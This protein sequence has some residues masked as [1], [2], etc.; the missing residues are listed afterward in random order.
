MPAEASTAG[1][2]LTVV[3]CSRSRPAQLAECLERLLALPTERPVS[4]VVVDNAPIDNRAE[5]VVRAIA[6]RDGRFQYARED[7]P[8]LSFARNRGLALAEDTFIAFLDDD[9]RPSDRWVE[10]LL[11][12][13][14]QRADVACVT[15]IVETASVEAAAERYFEARVW[16]SAAQERKVFDR[17]RG[18]RGS[19][20][21]P[22]AAGAF[23]TGANMA[24]RTAVLRE[25]GGFDEALGAGS[26]AGG[27]E[28]LDVFVR[29][30]RAGFAIAYEPQALVWH[31]HRA[32]VDAL[33]RQM[34]SYGRGLSAYLCKYLVSPRT[35]VDLVSRLPAGLWHLR[36]LAHRSA[37]ASVETQLPGMWREELRGLLNGPGA[38][39][40]A[41]RRQD[42]VNRLAV[43]P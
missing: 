10:A 5:A 43:A 34:R 21:H 3:V 24:F 16:W 22:Y 8:G 1:E 38:Y 42:P 25:L 17:S 40:R 31:H 19:A 18:P 23:G 20:L 9:V 11:Q 39:M 37:Q 26:P 13:F 15:G 36:R 12:G 7:R 4:F 41:R 32:D 30:I 6:A 35:S 2:R 27:G 33:R 28:D 14:S 29:V